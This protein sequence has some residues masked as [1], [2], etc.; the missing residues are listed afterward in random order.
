[1]NKTDRAIAADGAQDAANKTGVPYVAVRLRE[2][3][4]WIPL[5]VAWRNGVTYLDED[6]RKPETKEA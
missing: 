2:R 5:A 6:V 4:T 3:W 1:M